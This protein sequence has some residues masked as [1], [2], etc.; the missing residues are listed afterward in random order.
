M[1]RKKLI[2]VITTHPIQYMAPWYRDI[3]N[4]KEFDFHVLFFREPNAS[5]Q[6]I[7]FGQAFKWDT[8]LRE[9]YKNVVLGLPEGG[10]S[11]VS[12][13]ITLRRHIAFHKPDVILI[14]GWNEPLL[15]L[16]YPML[17]AMRLPVIVRGEAND[18]R[19]RGRFAR[20][21]HRILLKFVDA[22]V[23]IGSANRRFYLMNGLTKDKIFN[24]A[25]FVNTKHMLAM[26]LANQDQ[27]QTLRVT[28]GF[29]ENDFVFTF[30]GKHVPFKR[31]MMIVEAAALCRQKGF[32]VKL[33][34]AGSGELTHTLKSRAQ[35]L[36]VKVFF[37]GFLNQSEMWKAYVSADV[38]VLPSTN[39]ETWGLVTNEA[40]LFGLPV[41]VCDEVGCAE[42]L[43]VE[44]ET[45]YTFNGQVEDLANVMIRIASDRNRAV[46]MGLAGRQRVIELFSMPVA[47][48]GLLDAIDYVLHARHRTVNA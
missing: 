20:T 33:L 8:P 36:G 44:G 24:G 37:T 27:R 39:G 25:Y 40:M 31:P 43:V 5:Q 6:G 41:I 42:D 7:G 1:T 47:T 14:T 34:F 19:S 26:S 38:F 16:A 32:P 9:G 4:I 29:E 21:V 30:V 10:R 11:L 18:L 46:A 2:F 45:G 12:S 35:E 22:A 15:A 28:Q 13:I 48:N 17:K 3:D 23:Q